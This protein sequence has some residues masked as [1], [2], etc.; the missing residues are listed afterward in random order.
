MLRD[1]SFHGFDL[2][3]QGDFNHWVELF[4]LF[5]EVLEGA[6]KDRPELGLGEPASGGKPASELPPFPEETCIAI[7]RTTSVILEHCSNK[8]L[9]HSSDVSGAR[10]VW[11]WAR[12]GRYQRIA[13][14][15]TRVA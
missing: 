3:L 10:R 4:N 2:C 8:H 7:L 12:S 15:G 5:D 1:L 13:L 11:V 9:Y 14:A 6:N